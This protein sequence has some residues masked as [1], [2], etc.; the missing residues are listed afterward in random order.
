[1]TLNEMKQLAIHSVKK[2][3]PT[4][5]SVENVDAALQDG[6]KELAGSINQFMKNR[7]DIYEILIAAAEEIVPNRVID[8]MG[9]FAEVKSVPQG[10]KTRFKVSG[11]GKM[12]AKQFLTR[13]GLSGVYET[14]RLDTEYFEV[15]AHAIGGACSIDFERMLD[16][17]ENLSDLMDIMTEGLVDSLYLEVQTA[18]RSALN[19]QGR[20]AVNKYTGNG[21]NAAEM[22]KLVNVVKAYGSGAV[23]MAPPEFVG[24]MG[25]DAIVPVSGNIPGVYHPQDIDAIH[26]QGYINIFRGTPVVQFKN[27]FV[28]TDNVKT[29]IDPQLAYVLPTGGNKVVKIV[30]EGATQVNDFKNR[31]NSMEIHFY[32]KMGAAILTHYNWAIYQNTGIAQTYESPYGI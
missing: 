1:M 31:D 12:R 9:I 10:Q 30:L 19:A 23:I 14:F 18:L 4:T 16:G 3:A 11:L 21:F 28:D 29:W 7:Y 15:G 6:F 26:N 17:E 5:F 8:G 2:T 22:V 24:A 20:P 32:K 13:V 25:P 27:S